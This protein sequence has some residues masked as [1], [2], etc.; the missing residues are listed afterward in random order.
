MGVRWR[1]EAMH[2][3]TVRIY[4]LVDRLSRLLRAKDHSGA[5]NP[6]QWQVLRYLEWCNEEDNTAVRLGEYLSASKGTISQTLSALMRKGLIERTPRPGGGYFLHLT[7]A[8][9]E[10]LADD[11]ALAFRAAMAN[12]PE[13][14]QQE[15]L[16]AMQQL[17]DL[18]SGPGTAEQTFSFFEGNA[19]PRKP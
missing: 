16:S 9:R 8:G 4:L 2:P 17:L 12:L 14:R 10:K 11:P 7:E 15:I 1:F 6:A 13:E 18:H 19:R 5:L 3:A